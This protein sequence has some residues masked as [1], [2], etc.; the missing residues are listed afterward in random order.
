MGIVGVEGIGDGSLE[1]AV[2]AKPGLV[3]QGGRPR[4]AA[5]GSGVT[6]LELMMA[7]AVI[8]VALFGIVS[9]ILYTVRAKEAQREL[10]FAKA[11]TERKLD[12]IRSQPWSV[13][14]DPASPVFGPFSVD[15]LA[16]PASVDGLGKGMVKAI[17]LHSD[18]SNPALVT[19]IDV[20]VRVDWTGISGSASYSMSGMVTR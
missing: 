18:P 4:S 3:R 7:M 19:L 11:A 5:R 1:V 13:L 12:E 17:A 14:S 10:G 20:Q 9:L 2:M 16:N 6:L 15:G 8:V